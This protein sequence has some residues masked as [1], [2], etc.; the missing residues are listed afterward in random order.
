MGFFLPK[1]GKY[2]FKEGIRICSP[3]RQYHR[4]WTSPRRRRWDLFDWWKVYDFV[5]EGGQKSRKNMFPSSPRQYLFIIRPRPHYSSWLLLPCQISQEGSL[6][7][8]QSP[9]FTTSPLQHFYDTFSP[10]LL[11]ALT[12]QHVTWESD[13]KSWTTKVEGT[14]DPVESQS[15]GQAGKK[16]VDRLRWKQ[17]NPFHPVFFNIFRFYYYY[18]VFLN[19]FLVL[20]PPIHPSIHLLTVPAQPAKSLKVYAQLI[21]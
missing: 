16:W 12:S 21:F 11:F 20:L 13:Y 8:F 6:L 9:R 4:L 19:I 10:V 15:S 3:N 7:L 2:L 5:K 17:I 14:Q 18:L 1:N